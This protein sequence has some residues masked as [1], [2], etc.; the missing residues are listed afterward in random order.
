MTVNRLQ[1]HVFR[2]ISLIGGGGVVAAL[3]LVALSRTAETVA[4]TVEELVTAGIFGGV[5]GLLAVL[6]LY[7]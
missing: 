7:R 4:P 5:V 2:A 1:T 6:G 3:F